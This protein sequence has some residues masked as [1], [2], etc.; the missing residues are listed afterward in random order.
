MPIFDQMAKL[1][2][3]Q[4]IFASDRESGLR[5][6][7]AIHDTTLGSAL[8]G[9]R[10]WDYR[11]EGELI[12]DALKLSA[13]MT[14]KS[15]V[16]RCN[17]GGGKAVIWADPETD[18]SEPL[19][20]AF[21]RF[22]EG[23]R[24]RFVTGTDLGTTAEDFLISSQET[25]WLVGLPEYAGGS[26][27]TSVTTAYGVFWGLKAAAGHLWGTDDL[28]GRRVAVQGVGK[29][30][31]LLVQHL[32]QAGCEVVVCDVDERRCQDMV[33]KYDLQVIGVDEIY[34]V[35]CDV[36]SPCAMGG[37]LN[38]G[39]VERLRCSIVAG[40]ANNQL[41][42]DRMGDLMHEKEI[43][44]VPDYIINA[45]GLIQA[46]DEMHGFDRERAMRKT[47]GLYELLQRCFALADELD[48]PPF[49]AADHLVRERIET[50]AQVSR[51][52]L[53]PACHGKER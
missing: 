33:A 28:S 43:L 19:L 15:A 12:D 30:G 48:I 49:E 31:T 21:G 52:Y 4:L 47:A 32:V 17:H 34:D 51:I 10:M 14:S 27:D 44:Y 24:G 42:E 9:C 5:G 39:T 8:G 18:K 46:A 20:R 3:E 1:G 29:V 11:G 53:P 35:E 25:Q 13:G 26:G 36:F 41:A 45:G 23:L 40:A 7:I 50:L 22:V 16:T 37:I 38:E 2:H 6:I